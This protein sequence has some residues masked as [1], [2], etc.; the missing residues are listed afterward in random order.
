M[1]RVGHSVAQGIIADTLRMLHEPTVRDHCSPE[2]PGNICVP[3]LLGEESL[4]FPARTRTQ[5]Q[6]TPAPATGTA[7]LLW[8]LICNTLV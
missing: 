6:G 4:V 2:F 8:M 7:P 5:P 3:R 1:S